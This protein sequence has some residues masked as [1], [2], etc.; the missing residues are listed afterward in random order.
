MTPPPE[1]DEPEMQ[2]ESVP[3]WLMTYADMITLCMAFFVL[4]YSFSIIDLQKF[5]D[6]AGSIGASFG[7]IESKGGSGGSDGLLEGSSE[8]KP[9]GAQELH[10]PT[11]E[12]MAIKAEINQLVQ[13]MG[14]QGQVEVQLV[15]EGFSVRVLD[16]ILFD[17]GSADLRPLAKKVLSR[18]VTALGQT[19]YSLRVEGHTDSLPIST[20]RFPSNWELSAARAA[21][22]VHHLVEMRLIAPERLSLAGYGPYRPVAPNTTNVGRGR[23]RRIELVVLAPTPEFNQPPNLLAP[24]ID[25]S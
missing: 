9:F 7:A 16:A 21:T 12:Y 25:S 6:A 4:L 19:P 18:I 2:E 8:A 14:L 5:K 23:N 1:D 11:G 10:I 22:V 24:P 20:P 3:R 15:Q 17:S 13:E